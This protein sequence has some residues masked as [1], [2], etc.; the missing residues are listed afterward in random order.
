MV[1]V[2]KNKVDKNLNKFK[3]KLIKIIEINRFSDSNI[4]IGVYNK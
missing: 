1:N 4:V 2:W 3:K